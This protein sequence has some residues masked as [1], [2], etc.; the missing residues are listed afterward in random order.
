MVQHTM[1]IY[2]VEIRVEAMMVMMMLKITVVCLVKDA[3]SV[4]ECSVERWHDQ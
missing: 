4:L 3:L 1:H 2:T